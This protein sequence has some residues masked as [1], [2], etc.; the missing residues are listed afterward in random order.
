MCW[1][2]VAAAG[3]PRRAIDGLYQSPIAWYSQEHVGPGASLRMRNLHF[4]RPITPGCLFCH[5][6]RFEVAEGRSPVFHG[7]AIGCE[8]C[9]GPGE[10]HARQPGA[11]WRAAT[12]RS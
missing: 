3:V 6:N 10:L 1:A 2:R 5:A 12:G 11:R 4:D 7:L 8:R 9:H